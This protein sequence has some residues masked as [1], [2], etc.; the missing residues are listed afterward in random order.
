MISEKEPDRRGIPDSFKTQS[1]VE[2]ISTID[3]VGMAG[4]FEKKMLL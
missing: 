2:I 4:H 1:G 3:T